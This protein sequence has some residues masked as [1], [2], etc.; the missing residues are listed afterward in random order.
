MA[1]PHRFVVQPHRRVIIFGVFVL[2]LAGSRAG[3]CHAQTWPPNAQPGGTYIAQPGD[4]AIVGQTLFLPEYFTIKVP[5]TIK[6][7]SWTFQELR[8]GTGAT[9]DLSAPNI[10]PARVADGANATGGVGFGQVGRT[11][12]FG[13]HGTP[14]EAGASLRLV[15]SAVA[16]GG[17]LWI[18][19]DGGRGGDAGNGGN[20]GSGGPSSCGRR[21]NEPLTHGGA[22]GAGGQGGNGGEGGRPGSVEIIVAGI[23][24]NPIVRQVGLSPTWPS[25]RPPAATGNTGLVVIFSATGPGG[26]AGVGGRGGAGGGRAGPNGAEDRVCFGDGTMR[27]G[28][29]GPGGPDGVNGAGATTAPPKVEVWISAVDDQVDVSLNGVVVATAQYGQ[30][31]TWVDVAPA[32]L[33]TG[34]HTI[35]VTVTN[36]GGPCQGQVRVKVNGT[37][38]A[39][40]LIDLLNRD[41]RTAAGVCL[42]ATRVLQFE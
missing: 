21:G 39:D 29:S 15:V 19:S 22:G 25:Q 28:R 32:G 6:Q 26:R 40:L 7:L 36:R 23:A 33:P 16:G 42:T 10:K 20:G 38:R 34:S 5:A 18:R 1:T 27:V 8:F 4:E 31:T 2:L 30:R 17:S 35:S 14:G 13:V 24:Q 12:G 41:P 9:I 11:G 3:L 37:E